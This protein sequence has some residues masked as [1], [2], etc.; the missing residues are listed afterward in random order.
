M[1][2][3]LDDAKERLIFRPLVGFFALRGP[4]ERAGDGLF[5]IN[6]LGIGR[7][8]FV[9]GHD[10]VCAELVLHFDAFGRGEVVNTSVDVGFE[11]DAGVVDSVQIREREDLE[12]AGIGEDWAG[13]GHELVQ[14]AE[15]GDDVLAG[16]EH[17]V[18]GVGEDDLRAGGGDMIRKNAFDGAL[19]A[20]G[21]EGGGVEG[22]VVCCDV[23]G[24]GASLGVRGKDVEA[25]GHGL[26][27]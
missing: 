6:P 4:A 11:G 1:S 9:E 27:L 20:D 17:E 5:V 15:L 7:R 18:I 16:A 23:G 14:V 25:Q 21:H 19:R 3:A 13:P 12:A 8:T 10:D 26:G 22:A 2:P 24:A